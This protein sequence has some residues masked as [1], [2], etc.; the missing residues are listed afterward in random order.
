ML[1]K[2]CVLVLGRWRGGIAQ[3]EATATVV[4]IA[5]VTDSHTEWERKME[6]V[7]GGV[8]GNSRMFLSHPGKLVQPVSAHSPQSQARPPEPAQRALASAM[9]QQQPRDPH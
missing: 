6:G 8:L 5:A 7:K 4:I 3:P 9:S 2:E 1:N